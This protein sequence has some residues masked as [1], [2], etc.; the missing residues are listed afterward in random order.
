MSVHSHAK[1]IDRVNER[2][3]EIERSPGPALVLAWP[4]PS[5]IAAERK[6]KTKSPSRLC[7]ALFSPYLCTGVSCLI[8]GALVLCVFLRFARGAASKR[9]EGSDAVTCLPL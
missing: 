4:G 6:E 1:S 2:S 5:Y 7:Y 9:N 8:Y 3:V